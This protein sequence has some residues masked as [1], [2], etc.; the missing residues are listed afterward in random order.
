[1]FNWVV[2]RTWVP[3]FSING[4]I[5]WSGGDGTEAIVHPLNRDWMVGSFQYGLRIRTT[6]GGL[7]SDYCENPQTNYLDAYWSAPLLIDP[8]D[9]MNIYH[10]G[11]HIFSNKQFGEANE[12]REEGS[13]QIGP[14]STAVIAENNSNIIVA[15]NDAT[16]VLSTDKGESWR[17]ISQGLPNYIIEALA[18][19]PKFDSTLVVGYGPFQ[20][21]NKKVFISHDLGATWTN[22]T[23]N[24]SNITIDDI[25]IDHTKARNIYLATGIGLFVKPMDGSTWE[26]FN[27]QLPNMSVKDLEIHFGS[28]T[29]KA[30]TWG[31]GLWETTL[32]GRETFPK[33]RKVVTSIPIT[34]ANVPVNSPQV[35]SAVIAYQ[36]TIKQV[37]M[38]WSYNAKTLENRI[39]LT[40]QADQWVATK[41][42]SGSNEGDAVFFKIVAVGTNS[43]T[44]ETYTFMYRLG[45]CVPQEFNSEVRACDFAVIGQDTVSATGP[46]QQLFIDGFGCDSLLNFQVVI[47]QLP[48]TS[49]TIGPDYLQSNEQAGT[50]YQWLNC[51]DQF[52]IVEGE[53]NQVLTGVGA[54]NFA[55]EVHKNTCVLRSECYRLQSAATENLLVSDRVL[56]LPNPTTGV[57]QIVA[58]FDL[59]GAGLEIID[60]NGRRVFSGVILGNAPIYDLQLVP[61]IYFVKVVSKNEINLGKLILV[62]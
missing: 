10:V 61:G 31:R 47:D 32:L 50:A 29:L 20:S 55:V 6:N 48:D 39:E 28:N 52:S 38:L 62:R 41:P 53:T 49:V 22:I 42:I 43:D 26:L 34:K 35:I 46:Y 36:Q 25:V 18:I 11:E 16:L 58:D 24:L 30:G 13:P 4:W 15:S 9:H 59:K 14:L 21:E 33:I 17:V 45:E 12:W 56:I 23:F 37:F 57:F 40:F 19:D 8:A 1:M 44:S 60:L 7:T 3:V 51:D 27:E 54:G 2:R 5:E